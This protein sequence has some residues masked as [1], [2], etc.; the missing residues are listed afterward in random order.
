MALRKEIENEQRQSDQNEFQIYPSCI[1]RFLF[2]DFSTKIRHRKLKTPS[3]YFFL[4]K[5]S[6]SD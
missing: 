2:L 5:I 3:F 4:K 6:V 1:I